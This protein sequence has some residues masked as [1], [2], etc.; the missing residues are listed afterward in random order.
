MDTMWNALNVICNKSN[1]A[2]TVLKIKNKTGW[3][4]GKEKSMAMLSKKSS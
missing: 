1:K 3:W 2:T 4:C